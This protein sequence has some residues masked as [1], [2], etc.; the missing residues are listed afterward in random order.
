MD[1]GD[2]VGPDCGV[3]EGGDAVPLTVADEGEGFLL[4]EG[5]V[6]GEGGSGVGVGPGDEGVVE[7]DG[8]Q[9]DLSMRVSGYITW[10]G[11]D[12][13]GRDDLMDGQDE[14]VYKFIY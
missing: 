14:E 5:V 3:V 6:G 12:V 8:A 1:E 2:D 11:F 7:G 4:P 13:E 9:C 10:Q